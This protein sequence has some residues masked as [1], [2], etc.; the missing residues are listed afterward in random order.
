MQKSFMGTL[1]F[2]SSRSAVPSGNRLL[3]CCMS[4]SITVTTW[5]EE[6]E[7]MS[8]REVSLQNSTEEQQK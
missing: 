5:T 6:A 7:A 3:E 4:G 1:F 2:H 8:S